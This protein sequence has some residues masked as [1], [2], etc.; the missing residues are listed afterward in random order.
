M[1]IKELKIKD[2]RNYEVLDLKLNEKVNIILGSNAQGK[3]NLLE[4]IYI[5]SIG[6]SFRTSK[7][8]DMI[9]FGQDHAKAILTFNK[10]LGELEIEIDISKD[11]KKNVKVDGVKIKKA[12]QLLD[13]V[14]IVIFSPDDLKI[15]KDEPEKRRKFIDKELCQIKPSYYSDLSNYKKVLLERNTYLKENNVD[16]DMMDIW[17]MQLS[18]YGASLMMKRDEFIKKIS[19][20]SKDIHEGITNNK[21]SLSLKYDPNIK[22]KD[23]LGEQREYFYNLLKTSFEND[24]K[25]RTT[26]RG[27]H[28]DDLEFFIK[29][30]DNLINVRNFGSQ[31]QQR[32]AALSLKLAEIDIIKKETGEDPILLL[33][34]VLSELDL[35]RQNYLIKTLSCNQ[36][37]ITTAEMQQKILSE[38]P[39]ASLFEVVKGH[40]EKKL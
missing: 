2:F 19:L 37:F 1:Y 3:T 9:R 20:I 34:D 25:M 28:K 11:H 21:E 35:E 40:V 27:P 17:D 23:S 8:S 38:F 22:L 14:Y 18:S 7:D 29:N 13:N 39:D 4:A 10:D 15:V 16:P 24:I 12:S 5:S 6:R 33:D 26:T 30:D 32:T 31:G 36:L